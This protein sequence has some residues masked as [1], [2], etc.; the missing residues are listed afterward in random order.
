MKQT[1][2][3]QCEKLIK[4]GISTLE[5]MAIVKCNAVTVRR[6]RKN[7]GVKTASNIRHSKISREAR[8]DELERREYAPFMMAHKALNSVVRRSAAHG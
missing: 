1:K 7:L 5:I 8:Y 3:D 6:A 2:L 4:E